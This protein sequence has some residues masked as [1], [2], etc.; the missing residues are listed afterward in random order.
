MAYKQQTFICHSTG[1]WKSKVSLVCWPNLTWQD[2]TSCFTV[3][4]MESSPRGVFLRALIPFMGAPSL[5]S[6][7]LSNV[8]PPHT[9]TWGLD[10][11]LWI[12]G[13][14]TYI[15]H[16]Y[17]G[18]RIPWLHSFPYNFLK[19]VC[20]SHV[21]GI[22]KGTGAASPLLTTLFPVLCPSLCLSLLPLPSS[23]T[24]VHQPWTF[25]WLTALFWGPKYHS[26]TNTDGMTQ[27][28]GKYK[29]CRAVLTMPST[30]CAYNVVS[31][32]CHC[33]LEFISFFC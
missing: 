25:L 1:S 33:C 16:D 15:K 28:P 18:I 14:C 24:L 19:C 26:P 29:V 7:P 20:I 21:P 2:L 30:H 10:F 27:G 32:F 5:W 8:P 23:K 12:S 17:E 31:R 13:N 22:P 6:Y 3:L 9:I 4:L 11:H